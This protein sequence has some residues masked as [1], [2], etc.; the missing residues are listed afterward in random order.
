MTAPTDDQW[1]DAVREVLN[2]SHQWRPEDLAGGV[3]RAAGRLGIDTRVY[4]VDHEQR[5]LRALPQPG[6]ADRAELPVDETDA[7]RAYTTVRSVPAPSAEGNRCWVP[8]VN[9]TDRLGV[10]EFVLPAGLDAEAMPVRRRCE[11]VAGLVGHLVTTTLPRGDGLHL[12]RRTG[13]M[14]VGTEL[15]GALVPPLTVSFDEIVISATLEP[16]YD[17]G[18]DGFDYALDGRRPRFAILDAAGRGLRAGL[19]CAVALAAIRATRRSGGDLRRQAAAA[20]D[21]LREQFP[22]ARFATAVLAELDLD[23]GMLRYVNAG[24]PPPLLLR[25]GRVVRRLD[26]GRRVPLGIGDG[27][28]VEYGEERLEPDDRLLLYTDGVTEARTP[29]GDQFG[30]DRL[31][32]MA[33]DGHRAG[34]APPETLRRLS[35]AIL[36]HQQSP[37]ADDA[38]LMLVEWSSRAARRSVP[39]AVVESKG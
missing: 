3:A 17:V 24:H 6:A 16:R 11:T 29:D 33:E 7:G 18:G 25:A 8:M 39:T 23:T 10:M 5:S 34:L 15:L 27:T 36:E 21:N 1:F 22:D 4:L 37:P 32:G 2:W 31:V 38:T 26:G 35:R 9:G 30:V 13:P 19:A 12:A 28:P 14:T 20:D